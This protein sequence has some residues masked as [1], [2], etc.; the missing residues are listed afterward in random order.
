MCSNVDEGGDCMWFQ[1]ASVFSYL[2][3]CPQCHGVD[4]EALVLR[5]ELQV[6]GEDYQGA[7]GT[8]VFLQC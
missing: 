4:H 7:Q 1:E 6:T 2:E 8:F 5:S 3:L